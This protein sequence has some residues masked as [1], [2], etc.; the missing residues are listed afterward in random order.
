[1]DEN[2]SMALGALVVSSI[3]LLLSIINYYKTFEPSLN[4]DLR[5][6]GVVST[7]LSPNKSDITEISFINPTKNKFSDLSIQCVFYYNEPLSEID[8]KSNCSE[9]FPQSIYLGP[10]DKIT[11]NIDFIDILY[12]IENKR[13]DGNKQPKL[14][15][16]SIHF[17]QF[18]TSE[19]I[20]KYSYTFLFKNN[21]YYIQFRWN[22]LSKTW[23]STTVNNY[24]AVGL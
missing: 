18:S 6:K 23:D 9:L 1:M 12:N 16:K 24:Y 14:Q 10:S 17:S 8:L 13:R 11:M 19:I 4:V 5:Y 15:P 22:N 21:S 3:S 7:D 20:F 2:L